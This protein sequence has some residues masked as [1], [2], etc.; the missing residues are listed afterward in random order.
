MDE[1]HMGRLLEIA[2]GK[3][4]LKITDLAIKLGVN[5]RT[6]YNWFKMEVIDQLI[7]DR[8]SNIVKYDFAT[9]KQQV[10]ILQLKTEQS[11]PLRDDAYWKEKYTK[12]LERY[13]DLLAE[14]LKSKSSN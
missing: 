4:G 10:T 5:R 9:G 7:I 11:L 2:I 13:S 6:L 14:S 8:I 1:I 12:L 3:S